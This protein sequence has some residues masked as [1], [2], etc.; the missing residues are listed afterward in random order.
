MTPA[1]SLEDTQ[2]PLCAL[3]PFQSLKTVRCFSGSVEPVPKT[4]YHAVVFAKENVAAKALNDQIV[5][6]RPPA[7][8]VFGRL[9]GR[10]EEGKSQAYCTDI[11]VPCSDR[12]RQFW[13]T[14]TDFHWG[15]TTGSPKFL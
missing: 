15:S 10:T 6:L 12:S 3:Q 9:L 14:S 4:S 2:T 13:P 5:G 1:T 7:L 8:Q 11:D